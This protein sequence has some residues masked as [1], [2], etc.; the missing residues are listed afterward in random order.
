MLFAEGKEERRERERVR[1]KERESENEE[2]VSRSSVHP[3]KSFSQS[4]VLS[5]RDARNNSLFFALQTPET[6]RQTDRGNSPNL[7]SD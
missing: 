7:S 1:E 5:P 6:E 3:S 2:D 4:V